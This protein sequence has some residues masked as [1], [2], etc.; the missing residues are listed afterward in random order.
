MA[1]LILC[2]FAKLKRRKF[3]LFLA[4]SAF[5]FPIPVTMILCTPGSLAKYS[6]RAKAFDGLFAMIMGYSVELL[7]PCVIGIL[8]AILFFMERDNDTFKSLC[9]IPVTST[10]MVLAKIVVLFLFGSLFCVMSTIATI[11]CGS[12]TA[13]MEVNGIA[14]KLLISIVLGVL[15]TAGTLPLVV[16]IVF[17]SKT[18]I[19]SVLTCAFYSVLAL[20]VECMFGSVP[21]LLCW[22][23]PIPLTTLWV[24]G[25][26]VGH[27]F[28]LKLSEQLVEYI[29]TTTQAA[30]IIGVIAVLSIAA[31]DRVYRRRG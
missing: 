19:F 30:G 17:F 28:P 15:I 29:P 21:K 23:A 14:Y 10:Q 7:L 24:A 13:A 8:A 27:G 20:T 9:T 5:L 4:L 2:E 6:D 11:L 31:V 18:Y 25:Q 12:C 3:V 1:E 22:M 26:L 16:L